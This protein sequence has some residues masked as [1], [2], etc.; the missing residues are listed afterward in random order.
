MLKIF[1]K[2][3]NLENISKK[4]IH[5]PGPLKSLYQYNHNREAATGGF[6]KKGVLKN[7][8]KFTGKNMY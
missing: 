3:L 1:L 4:C 7:F 8:A 2:Y 6:C 5:V